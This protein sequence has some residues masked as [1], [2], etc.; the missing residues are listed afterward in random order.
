MS[1]GEVKRATTVRIPLTRQT[2][3]TH[4][5]GTGRR[6]LEGLS[7]S[8]GRRIPKRIA[9]KTGIKTIGLPSIPTRSE[10]SARQHAT[11]PARTRCRTTRAPCRRKIPGRRIRTSLRT[12][13]SARTS[14]R[15]RGIE[16]T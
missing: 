11:R 14:R 7:R 9:R 8:A 3:A 13:G 6:T 10:Q 5:T 1:K 2:S 16:R 15:S 4:A 12:S